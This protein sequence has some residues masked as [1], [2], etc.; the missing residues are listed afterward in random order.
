M[1]PIAEGSELGDL[2]APITPEEFLREHWER[3]PLHVKGPPDKFEGLFDMQA[4]IRAVHRQHEQGI[5]IRVSFDREHDSGGVGRHLPIDAGEIHRYFTQ[6]ASVCVDP[7]D[8]GDPHLAR[9]AAAVKRQLGFP[10]RASV[11][12]YLS[13]D[14]CGF[15]THF[16]AA[17]ATTLQIAG[18]KRWRFSREPG[19]EFPPNNALVDA[20]GA[21]RYSGRLPSSL[22]PWE[23][24]EK[25]DEAG[26]DEA[27]LEP[28]DVLCLPAGTWHNAKAIGN[29]L[30]LNLSF[31]PLA[32]PDLLHRALASLLA[33]RTEW[34]RGVPASL[35]APAGG[36]PPAVE[37]FFR[38]RLAELR[39]MLS[40]P[41]A[42]AH[43]LQEEWRASLSDAGPGPDASAATYRGPASDREPGG[44][45]G[46]RPAAGE[47]PPTG[48]VGLDGSLSCV[49]TVASLPVAVDWYRRV[50][51]WELLYAVSEF[52]WAELATGTPGVRIGLS[53]LPTPGVSGGAV[54]NFGVEDLDDS[55]RGLEAE[56]VRFEGPT[57]VIEG[58]ARLATFF[59]PDGNRLM[60]HESL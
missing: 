10:G 15:N 58:L 22:R 52:G 17:I 3:R 44:R 40:S 32:F 18:R 41:D 4:F 29:S 55:R 8:R 16:D 23:R 6:G 31:A 36:V 33:E 7:I 46:P 21:V 47:G 60:L 43:R 25:V 34:R 14:G 50:L 42:A 12:C 38:A 19:V 51:G 28:G 49:L 24:V 20:G 30:A 11:K 2:L 45:A 26:F 56:G 48:P 59:D 57:R 37:E 9:L 27:V 1:S 13:P 35:A 39:E 54:L 53:E 5:L